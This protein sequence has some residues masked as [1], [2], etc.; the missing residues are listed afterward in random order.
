MIKSI[1]FLARRPE[2]AH[3][4][5]LRHWTEVHAPMCDAVP[6]LRGYVLNT[7]VQ[8]HHRD[9]VVALAMAPF[10][11]IAQT[12]FD[13][14]EARAAAAASPQGKAWHADGASIIGGIRSFVT[15][16]MH[17]VPLPAGAKRPPLKALTVIARRKD[18]TAEQFRRHWLDIHAP[19]ARGVPELR[20]FTLSEI[21]E[22]QFRPDI[23]PFP[24]DLPIDGFAESWVDSVEARAR[25]VA[26]PEA[27]R[28][29]ADGAR[30][31]GAVKIVLLAERVMIPP[32]R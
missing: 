14:L 20:G 25:M 9:D 19:M 2:L 26:S 6:G 16:E 13:S 1:A 32:P 27:Q 12:W 21:V 17:P 5:F 10:D 3:E 31:L 22:E 8:E 15:R 24:M 23:P 7:V 30:F 18:A 28:W 4:Q 11:G 29:F